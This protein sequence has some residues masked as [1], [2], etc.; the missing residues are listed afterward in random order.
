MESYYHKAPLPAPNFTEL[1]NNIGRVYSLINSLLVNATLEPIT[2]F[3]N[4]IMQNWTLHLMLA[5]T[6][7]TCLKAVNLVLRNILADLKNTTTRY[8]ETIVTIILTST[9]GCPSLKQESLAAHKKALL[10]LFM[11][12]DSIGNNIGSVLKHHFTMLIII[13]TICALENACKLVHIL[14]KTTYYIL[15]AAHIAIALPFLWTIALWKLAFG[16]PSSRSIEF[17]LLWTVALWKAVSGRSKPKPIKRRRSQRK[18]WPWL[19]RRA[20]IVTGSIKVNSYELIGGV[21]TRSQRNTRETAGRSPPSQFQELDPIRRLGARNQRQQRNRSKKRPNPQTLMEEEKDDGNNLTRHKRQRREDKKS[22]RKYAEVAAGKGSAEREQQQPRKKNKKAEATSAPPKDKKEE[23]KKA[24]KRDWS[25]MLTTDIRSEDNTEDR[26]HKII[27]KMNN[28]KK[29]KRKVPKKR[30]IRSKATAIRPLHNFG[31]TCHLNCALQVLFSTFGAATNIYRKESDLKRVMEAYTSGLN[32]INHVKQLM[33]SAGIR[34][35]FCSFDRSW[36]RVTRQ[37]TAKCRKLMSWGEYGQAALLKS[38]GK[39]L[40]EAIRNT[41]G[42]HASKVLKHIPEYA[43]FNL[44]FRQVNRKKCHIPLS[45]KFKRSNPAAK[46]LKDQIKVT[47]FKLS[48]VVVHAKAHFYTLIR[49]DPDSTHFIMADDTKITTVSKE[50]FHNLTD[51]NA[52]AVTYLRS[53]SKQWKPRYPIPSNQTVNNRNTM[54][55]PP[56]NEFIVWG[57]NRGIPIFGVKTF[58]KLMGLQKFAWSQCRWEGDKMSQCKKTKEEAEGI[59]NFHLRV[60]PRSRLT[61]NEFERYQRTLR[62]I[63]WRTTPVNPKWKKENVN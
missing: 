38:H 60:R 44:G 50:T 13:T 6:F 39:D 36:T 2:D 53:D 4:S 56:N 8:L 33:K 16:Q 41:Y 23:K 57:P 34:N 15:V 37:L 29:K 62:G 11:V 14:H 27:I 3:S 63:N 24:E 42:K 20:A 49:A 48:S 52:C 31:L 61:A 30:I 55:T 51:N 5:F 45:L 22:K 32:C 47:E 43:I 58:F 40:Q 10:C 9:P 18:A 59:N 54:Q 28:N 7:I 12:I 1:T 17:P 46:E 19:L 26:S 25:T 21:E 35:E